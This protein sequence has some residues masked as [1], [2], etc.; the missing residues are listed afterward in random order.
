MNRR[1]FLKVLGAGTAALAATPVVEY[2][3]FEGSIPP[4]NVED[5][6]MTEFQCLNGCI[7]EYNTYVN[8]SDFAMTTWI[9]KEVALAASQL[10][11]AMGREIE[12]LHRS[13]L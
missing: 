6:L 11:Q 5:G 7:A 4:F 12:H 2:L 8:F 3:A 13:A 9:D 1:K 10:S